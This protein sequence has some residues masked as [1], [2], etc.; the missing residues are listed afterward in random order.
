MART[1][2]PAPPTSSMP[3]GLDTRTLVRRAAQAAALLLVLVLVAVLAPGLGEVRDRL[4]GASPGWLALAVVFEVL[5]SLSYV[6]MFRPVF[7]SLMSWRSAA[8]VGLSEVGMGSIVP[9]SGA[10]GVALG[11]WVLSRA[12]MKPETIARRSVAFLLLKSSVNFA[13]VVVVGLLAFVGVVGPSESAWLTLFPAVLATL[14]IGLV[15][16][17]PRIPEG[18]PARDD[19]GRARKLWI[20]ARAAIVTGT[21]E[22]GVLLRRHDP[23][24]LAG[25]VGYWA[26]DN[27]ALWATFHAVG[28]APGVSVILLGYLIGQIGGL[29]PIPG[30]IGGID[31][32]LI[33]TL[34]VYGAPA[35]TA[36]AAVLAYRLILFW[37][38][39]L[40]GAVAFAS[41]RR[42]MAQPAGF[43][44]CAE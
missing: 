1:P 13:A 30:G 38:P 10:G 34:V 36:T 9:A 6:V 41:L 24:L 16:L 21:A 14:I 17:I 31:G 3:T 19:D 8:E 18:P 35:S 37:V 20:G 5:S 44:P 28:L 15:A 25:I 29:L 42:S 4:S 12:G 23:W 2:A 32:G 22:A 39:L 27:L 26:W 33:G 43:I 11:A 40:M 7:C